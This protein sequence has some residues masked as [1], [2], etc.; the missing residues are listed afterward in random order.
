[1]HTEGSGKLNMSMQLVTTAFD[2]V[3]N[4]FM[5]APTTTLFQRLKVGRKVYDALCIFSSRLD[6]LFS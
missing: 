1:M 3:L 6:F 5:N 2:L 4:I